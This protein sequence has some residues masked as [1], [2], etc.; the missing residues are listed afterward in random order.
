MMRWRLRHQKGAALL[1][2]M[3]TVAL[4][5]TFAAT[6]VW[7]QY[8]STEIEAAERA[9]VQSGWLLAAALDWARLILRE[10]ARSGGADH[11]AE[12]WAV[13]L[14]ETRLSSFLSMDRTISDSERNAFLSGQITDLQSRL[15]V[16]NLIDGKALSEPDVRSFTRLFAVLGLSASQLTL[17]TNQMLKA[18]LAEPNAP[19]MPQ[20]IDQLSWL[21]LTP[22]TLQALAPYITLL[23]QRTPVNLNTARAEVIYA[24]TPDLTL[25]LA[26]KLVARRDS[27]H[28]RSLSEA[29]EKTGDTAGQFNE[30]QHAVASRFFEVRGRLRLDQVTLEERAVVLRDGL[31][32]QVLWRS[33]GV[34]A[35]SQLAGQTPPLLVR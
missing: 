5:S 21:G 27:N 13:P 35:G 16:T 6:A 25:A 26:S 28:F 2:A 12:P 30:G 23:P 18:A 29:Q 22:Q 33:R 24:S 32:V 3:L 31:N 17:L 8:R 15:N 11:L 9:R 4:V 10:D 19:L 14:N 34:L 20:R 7:Q 1:V